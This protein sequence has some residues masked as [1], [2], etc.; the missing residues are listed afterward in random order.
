MKR[1]FIAVAVLT[2]MTASALS[3]NVVHPKPHK[4]KKHKGVKHH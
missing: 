3:A 2:V 1:F 4:V